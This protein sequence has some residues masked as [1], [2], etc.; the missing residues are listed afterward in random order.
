MAASK[1]ARAV[2]P[3]IPMLSRVTVE[4]AEGYVCGRT[5][6]CTTHPEMYD[7]MLVRGETRKVLPNL[8]IDQIDNVREPDPEMV[9]RMVG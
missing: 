3:S 2:S 7:V 1:P 8:R 4:G 6:A 5:W 9:A